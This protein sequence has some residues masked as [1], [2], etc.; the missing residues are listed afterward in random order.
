MYSTANS[1]ASSMNADKNNFTI[2]GN[3]YGL[4]DYG[5]IILE[6]FVL[7]AFGNRV[8]VKDIYPLIRGGF[9]SQLGI[10]YDDSVAKERLST[11][12]IQL[13]GITPVNFNSNQSKNIV[14]NL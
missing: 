13:R 6:R 12:N 14:S 1:I 10:T 5:D 3:G 4:D 9:E 2:Y 7:D 8:T 11:V